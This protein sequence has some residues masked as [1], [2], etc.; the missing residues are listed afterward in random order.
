M[1]ARAWGGGWGA[2]SE[3][4]R[5]GALR[6]AGV[7]HRRRRGPPRQSPPGPARGAADPPRPPT[8]R[9]LTSLLLHHARRGGP[10]AHPLGARP[11]AP[12]PKPRTRAPPAAAPRP[13]EKQLINAR[14]CGRRP[15]PA[16]RWRRR[17]RQSAGRPRRRRRRGGRAYWR[18]SACSQGKAGDGK[19]TICGE[20]AISFLFPFVIY[21]C[22]ARPRL[23]FLLHAAAPAHPRPPDHRRPGR[24]TR[25]RRASVCARWR[26]T[27]RGAAWARAFLVL[28]RPL[29]SSLSQLEAIKRDRAAAAATGSTPTAAPLQPVQANAET[30]PAPG[31]PEVGRKRRGEE[32]PLGTLSSPTLARCARAFSP[33][34][35]RPRPR[36]AGHHAAGPRHDARPLFCQGWR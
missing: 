7:F 33:G 30:T 20:P 22:P 5:R 13:P 28:M 8:G 34:A 11:A 31:Q 26:G 12:A 1:A 25:V 29:L 3:K 6:Q 35:R 2:R 27:M 10:A 9:C 21:F 15:P 14:F 16:A 24:R 4:K 18:A 17:Q 32:N 36:G 23:C 19:A